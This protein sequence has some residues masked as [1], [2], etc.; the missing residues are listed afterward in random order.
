MNGT[1][2]L[3]TGAAV[4]LMGLATLH[5][6]TAT[7]GKTAAGAATVTTH[8]ISG[9]VLY[10]EGNTLVGKVQPSGEIRAFNIRPGQQFMIDGQAR[11]INELKPGTVLNATVITTTQPMTVRTVTVTNG[12]VWYVSGNNVI[13][14]LEN[15][16]NRQY[17]VPESYHFTVGG[18]PATV[19][20]LRKGM[21][22]SGA[23]IVEAPMNEISTN[24]VITGK[25]PK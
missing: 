1:R 25:A 17:T 4:L 3:T 13:L 21:K 10:V 2:R 11:L 12:T 15:G 20:E 22:V 16:Q 19:Y 9:E 6:Q 14:T 24:A 18:K 8:E 5:A 7:T 23:K